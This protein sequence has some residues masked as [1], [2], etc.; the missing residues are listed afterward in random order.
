MY[1]D[2]MSLTGVIKVL[3]SEFRFFLHFIFRLKTH[4]SHQQWTE[5]VSVNPTNGEHIAFQQIR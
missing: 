3:N 5:E 2:F 4:R 1:A